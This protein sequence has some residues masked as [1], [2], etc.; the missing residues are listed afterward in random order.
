MSYIGHERQYE[1]D[2][3]RERSKDRERE[4]ERERESCSIDNYICHW[5]VVITTSQKVLRGLSVIF[6][7]STG[8]E[9]HFSIL[10]LD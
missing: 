3:E 2:R 7:G 1:V 6:E 4:R 10:D 5:C 9:S 8:V